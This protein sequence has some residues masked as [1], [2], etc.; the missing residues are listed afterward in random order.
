MV[1]KFATIL[2]PGGHV[3][4]LV[5]NLGGLSGFYQR[6]LKPETFDT[7]RLVTLDQLREWNGQ[8]GLRLA[9]AGALGSVVPQR[10]PRDK[11]RRQHPRLYSVLWRGVLGPATWLAGRGCFLAY[12]RLGVQFE[13]PTY[14]PYLYAIGERV[15]GSGR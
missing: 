14:S 10:F 5:P 1:A 7:H 4:T 9:T 3:V 8:P 2:R 15:P 12:A 6:W 11:L 13:G